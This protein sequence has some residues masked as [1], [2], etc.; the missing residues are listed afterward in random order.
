MGA[1]RYGISLRVLN[2]E[3]KTRREIPYL[4]AT[5]YYFV[6][7]INTIAYCYYCYYY[8]YYY[9]YYFHSQPSEMLT[10][11]PL[12]TQLSVFLLVYWFSFLSRK[13]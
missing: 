3:L 2:V 6:Y 11:K 9:Y 5:M 13:V 8:Y 12:N 10:P 7:Y 4:Q 1:R